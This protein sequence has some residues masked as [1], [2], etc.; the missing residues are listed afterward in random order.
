MQ[1]ALLPLSELLNNEVFEEAFDR[2]DVSFATEEDAVRIAD[3]HGNEPARRS[4][5][6][7][8]LR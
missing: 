7:T 8:L 3:L 1:D 5:D 6:C 2:F 4:G